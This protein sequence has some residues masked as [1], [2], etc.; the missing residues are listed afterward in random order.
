MGKSLIPKLLH[1]DDVER[2]DRHLARFSKAWDGATFSVEYRMHH[3]DGS[4]RRLRSRDTVIQ[5]DSEG[6]PKTILG[7]AHG[8]E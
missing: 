5:R 7:V 2:V 4:Y 6:R 1:P 8:R 3:R